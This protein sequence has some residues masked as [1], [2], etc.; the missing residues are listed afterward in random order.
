MSPE[1]QNASRA[2]ADVQSNYEA[3]AGG[4][5]KSHSTTKPSAR[6]SPSLADL[7]QYHEIE[8]GRAALALAHHVELCDRLRA[9][10]RHARAVQS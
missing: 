1:K 10:L 8:A 4:R 6:Q 5:F 2:K 9:Q 7:I 3:L